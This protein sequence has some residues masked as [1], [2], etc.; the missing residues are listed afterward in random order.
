MIHIST[1]RYIK[2]S[3]TLFVFFLFALV[4]ALTLIFT[5]MLKSSLIY[6]VIFVIVLY[7]VLVCVET[8]EERENLRR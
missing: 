5:L 1:N 6:T 7:T 8:R 4:F 3:C 2:M